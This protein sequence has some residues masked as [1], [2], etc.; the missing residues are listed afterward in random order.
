MEEGPE[1][2]APLIAAAT[3]KAESNAIPRFFRVIEGS[4][5]DNNNITARI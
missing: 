3:A 5:D 4:L 2:A 1:R